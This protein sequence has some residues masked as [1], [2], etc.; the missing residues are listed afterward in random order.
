M[1][2]SVSCPVLHN[3]GLT[4][5]P[6]LTHFLR[7]VERASPKYLTLQLNELLNELFLVRML[8]AWSLSGVSAALHQKVNKRAKSWLPLWPK[9]NIPKVTEP[10]PFHES[11][12]HWSQ[13]EIHSEGRRESLFFWATLC[14]MSPKAAYS[15]LVF[16]V[17]YKTSFFTFSVWLCSP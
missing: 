17:P 7:S 3:G 13:D 12:P 9:W 4:G 11:S 14:H 2:F 5:Y 15:T 6:S 1:D 16:R 8:W 10:L